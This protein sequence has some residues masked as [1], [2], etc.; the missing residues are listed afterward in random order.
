MSFLC[1]LLGIYMFVLFAR[2]ILSF[3]PHLPEAMVPVVRVVFVL[4]EPLLRLFR[5][6]IPPVRVGSIAFDVSF[7]LVFF[8]LIILRNVVCGA[9]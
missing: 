5:P 2:A 9:V 3:F 4:T 7:T 8:L 1:W 6:L